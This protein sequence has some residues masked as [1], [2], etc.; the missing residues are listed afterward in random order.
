MSSCTPLSVRTGALVVVFGLGLAS[1]AP[2]WAADVAPTT[3][4]AVIGADG[5][6]TVPGGP[7]SEGQQGTWV[8]SVVVAGVAAQVPFTVNNA[9]GSAAPCAA[10]GSA[11]VAATKAKALNAAL[12]HMIGPAVH[13][14]VSIKNRK[15]AN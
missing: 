13:Q 14:S 12:P 6:L 11:S 8:R 5:K 15:V 1:A 7:F 2:V 10:S 9:N 3:V 4:R